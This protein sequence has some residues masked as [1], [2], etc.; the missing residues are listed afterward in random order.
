VSITLSAAIDA[1]AGTLLV[2]G[3]SPPAIARPFFAQIDSEQV[4]VTAAGTDAWL[5]RRGR[6][7]T[8]PVAHAQNAVVTPL[9]PV[10][11]TTAP[12]TTPLGLLQ[13]PQGSVVTLEAAFVANGAGTYTAA[14]PIPAGATVLDVI[15]RNT[16]VWDNA[17]S[18]SMTCG[19]TDS[20]TGYFSATNVKTT[21][22]ADTNGAG[23]GLSTELSLGA[24]AGAYKGGGGKYYA[25]AQTL[26]CV[27]V[28]VG[29]GSAGRSRCLVRYTLPNAIVPTQV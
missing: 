2:T 9:Y 27:I 11:S 15:F 4:E 13:Q 12:Q 23:A 14:F 3:G 7:G 26:S 25:A 18:A 22:A 5:V 10:Q 29:A 17:T 16:V 20:A 19:D 8:Y 6:N 28:T 24:S 1:G 21:P